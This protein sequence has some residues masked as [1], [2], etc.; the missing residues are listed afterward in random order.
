MDLTVPIPSK[1]RDMARAMQIVMRAVY[2]QDLRRL[3]ERFAASRDLTTNTHIQKG[4]HK[5]GCSDTDDGLREWLD[6][7]DDNDGGQ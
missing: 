1:E 2:L 4:E 6:H 5:N 7:E 3:L